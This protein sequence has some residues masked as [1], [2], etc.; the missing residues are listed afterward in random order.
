[1]RSLTGKVVLLP[2][3]LMS[4]DADTSTDGLHKSRNGTVRNTDSFFKDDSVETRKITL[5]PNL[6][7]DD[8]SS[9]TV[10][11]VDSKEVR[12][13]REAAQLKPRG[14]LENIEKETPAPEKVKDD[15]RKKKEKKPGML[16]GLFKRKDKKSRNAEDDLDD[17][18][19]REKLSEESSRRNSPVPKSSGE[20]TRSEVPSSPSGSERS[21][22][23]PQ[24]YPSKLQKSP[25]SSSL[26]KDQQ[27]P[28]NGL[29][30]ERGSPQVPPPDRP[31]PTIETAASTMRV[32]DRDAEQSASDRPQ[33]LRVRASSEQEAEQAANHESRMDIKDGEGIFS[34]ASARAKGSSPATA[35]AEAVKKAKQRSEL[36][37]FESSLD[38][39]DLQDPDEA[40]AD[41]DNTRQTE[42]LSE[43]PIEVSPAEGRHLR[44]PP[45]MVDSSSQE[46][47]SVSPVSP[48]SSPEMVDAPEVHESK[49]DDDGNDHTVASSTATPTWSDASLRTYLEEDNDIRD[50]LV[51]VHDKSGV[52][53]AGPEHPFIGGL[54]R[55]E[56]AKLTDLTNVRIPFH[57]ESNP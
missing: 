16:S 25:A 22:A 52:Q 38:M 27:S 10:R 45:L 21:Q 49:T 4:S 19:F 2:A 53:P 50:L 47:A 32:V 26:T 20:T 9:S 31:A 15:V 3:R 41:T 23:M 24:K 28:Q 5:T 29:V 7:R 12:E 39:E 1:M 13:V 55:D 57:R 40:G 43:S 8:S 11:S 42:R 44:L 48:A 14:S 35:K 51:V 56:S 33:P 30:S 46:E 17:D 36:D 54:F 34:P 6:L 18:Q 37:D